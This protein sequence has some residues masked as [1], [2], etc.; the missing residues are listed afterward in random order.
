MAIYQREN[1]NGVEEHNTYSN[2]H[3]LTSRIQIVEE[4]EKKKGQSFP[5]RTK[6]GLACRPAQEKGFSVLPSTD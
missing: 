6:G 5:F 1:A 4:Y 3:R 2:Y